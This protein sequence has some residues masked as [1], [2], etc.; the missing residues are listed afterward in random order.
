MTRVGASDNFTV[1]GGKTM[2][3]GIDSRYLDQSID[4]SKP[5]RFGRKVLRLAVIERYLEKRRLEKAKKRKP[6]KK[7]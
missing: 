6:K 7:K 3:K 4:F 2:R 1:G 5:S